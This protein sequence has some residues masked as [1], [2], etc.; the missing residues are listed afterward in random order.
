MSE[1]AKES[2]K[3]SVRKLSKRF[4]VRAISLIVV[5]A[6]LA[7]IIIYL[8]VRFQALQ[9]DLNQFNGDL[10]KLMTVLTSSENTDDPIN[11]QRI[12]N[13]LLQSKSV[14]KVSLYTADQRLLWSSHETLSIT[15]DDKQ[16]IS[17]L[18]NQSAPISWVWD[19]QA[20]FF[21]ELS[22]SSLLQNI[23]PNGSDFATL[24]VVP[25]INATPF[26]IV[27]SIR[28]YADIRQMAVNTSVLSFI[29][30]FVTGLLVLLLFSALFRKV[31]NTI[32]NDETVLN[33]QVKKLSMLLEDNKE[34]Q[35]NMKSASSRAVELNERF[36]RRVGS[37]LHDGPAQSIGY[38]VL[39]LNQ[40]SSKQVSEELGHEFHTVKESLSESLEEIRGISS[41]LVLPELEHMSLEEAIHKVIERHTMNTSTQVKETYLNLPDNIPL[42]IKICAYRFAQ[43]GLNNAYKHGGADKCRFTAQMIDDVLHLSLKDNGMGFRMSTLNTDGGHLGLAGLKDRIESLGGKLNINSELGV[44]TAIK[45]SVKI[46][47]DDD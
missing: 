2:P 14:A 1:L 46:S 45:V 7:S 15:L 38:A 33:N 43:E 25:D 29:A 27:K 13:Q 20:Q 10:S 42:P 47:D 6:I 44:G 4:I 28:N 39:R 11:S 35:R 8:A 32:Q 19:H 12:V 21:D 26:Y 17:S 18:R 16:K 3:Y 41:G 30:V 22:V 34:L 24:S 31:S 5:M 37:D 40:V 36:L 9:Q 23:I